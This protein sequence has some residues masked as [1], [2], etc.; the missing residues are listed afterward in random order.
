MIGTNSLI[1]YLWA[2]VKGIHKNI[3]FQ[4]IKKCPNCQAKYKI[5][6]F[7]PH[8]WGVFKRRLFLYC[9][10]CSTKLFIYVNN[11]FHIIFPNLICSY[12][13]HPTGLPV[14]TRISTI[15]EHIGIPI[16]IDFKT[17]D[18]LI[19]FISDI[20]NINKYLLLL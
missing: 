4:K 2:W 6:L 3:F 11:Q 12:F 14:N 5:R 18:E 9:S 17:I 7:Q 10:K 1:I 20:K 19:V 16:V 15:P 8:L 13:G